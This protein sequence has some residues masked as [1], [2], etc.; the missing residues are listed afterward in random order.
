MCLNGNLPEIQTPNVDLNIVYD[1][2]FF[3]NV[4]YIVAE[5]L[6][7]TFSLIQLDSDGKIIWNF[8]LP[9]DVSLNP[10]STCILSNG[11]WIAPMVKNPLNVVDLTFGVM[12]FST[13][14][15]T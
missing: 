9:S 8:N 3:N 6:N 15:M 14:S 13:T 11:E 7:D 12:R 4:L 2:K 10:H 5:T 1:I